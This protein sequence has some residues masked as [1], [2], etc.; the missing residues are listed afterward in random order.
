MAPSRRSS[1]A[2]AV[3]LLAASTRVAAQD[4]IGAFPAVEVPAGNPL[5]PEKIRLGQ[6]L[7]FEEQLSSDDTMACATCHMPEAGGGEP[8]AAARSPGDDGVMHTPDDELGSP[9]MRRI[10]GAQRFRLHS[11]FGFERQVT[12][13]NSPTVIG[14]AFF[15]TQFWDTRALPTFRD[16]AGNVVL[17]EFASLETQAVEPILSSVEMGHEGRTWSDVTTKLA[18]V[19]P[20]DLAVDLPPALA[21]FV[22][23]AESY[24]PLFRAAFG[25][26]EITR[27]RIAMAIAS[28]ERTLVPDHTP[29][30]LGTLTP[31]QER[32]F[33]VFQNRGLCEVCHP[34]AER[35][36]TDGALR[37][38]FLSEHPRNVKTPSLRNVGL[39]QRFMSSGE[40]ASLDAVLAHYESVDFVAFASP[41][42]RVALLDFLANGLT[43]PRAARREP[44]FERPRLRSEVEPPGSRLFGAG[45]PGSGGRMPEMLADTPPALGSESFRIG[46]GDAAAGARALLALG[47]A[48]TPA[49]TTLLGVPFHVDVAPWQ[50]LRA[51]VAGDGAAT[52]AAVLPDDPALIGVELFAQWLVLDPG[53][54]QGV[55]ASRAA[56]F[57]LFSRGWHEKARRR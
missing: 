14:A 55:A 25:T 29:F 42:E 26:D 34:S 32:G 52:W 12:A 56:R 44:P 57:E 1:A 21:R 9:G 7:F 40:L 51:T 27:E 28:Y 10:D 50:L 18:R 6:A 17:S 48:R 16:L 20:L 30:D 3:L 35:L 47:L 2:L 46:L 33:Q 38:V 11:T 24:A 39:R 15:N 45:M 49:G 41:L 4:V 43:D 22:A 23:G 53:A 36:F 5:T 37:T 31:H 8:R 13:R 19:R 54:A